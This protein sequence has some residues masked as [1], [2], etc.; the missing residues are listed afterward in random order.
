MESISFDPVLPDNC[1]ILILGTMP[2]IKSLE[3][4]EYYAHE[5]NSFWPIIFN[6][7]DEEINLNYKVKLNLLIKN[8]IGLWDTLQFCYREGSLDSNIKNAEP[9]KI[10]DLLLQ[11][12][13]IR[14][15]IF[16]GKGA[17]KYYDKFHSRLNGIKYHSLPSTSPANARFKFEDKLNA[18]SIIKQLL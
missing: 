14:N 1:K 2:G 16:N 3:A 9:N 13:L 6:I 4:Q 17:E 18:W 11:K 10:T 7:F 8:G 5:R 15:V 12:E